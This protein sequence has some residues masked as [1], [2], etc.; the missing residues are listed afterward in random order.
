MTLK[1]LHVTLNASPTNMGYNEFYLYGIS[2]GESFSISTF[3]QENISF[4]QKVVNFAQDFIPKA[5][6]ASLVHFHSHYVMSISLLLSLLFK[7]NLAEK[8]IYTVHTS[9]S[10]LSFRNKIFFFINVFF[11]KRV[12]FCSKSSF[13]SFPSYFTSK[14]KC[15]YIRNGINIEFLST[16]RNFADNF[17]DGFCCLGRLV[18]LKGPVEVA[19]AFIDN[20]VNE[21]LTFIGSG[22]LKLELENLAIESN[23]INFTGLIPRADV[24]KRLLSTKYYI[25]NS[26]V[27]GMPIAALE[28]IACGCYPVLSKIEPHCEILA[29]GV[30][31]TFIEKGVFNAIS[32]VISID[33]DEIKERLKINQKIIEEKFSLNSM[34][35][36]YLE[37]YNNILSEK[38]NG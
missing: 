6:A 13:A 32:S 2:N 25:S 15:S 4:F 37:L 36:K 29:E 35:S 12:V 7:I 11:S 38:I 27:E 8:S 17:R 3:E 16:Q 21:S 19:Q 10:N 31:G 30:Y 23:R 34:H 33:E 9:Y 18:S 28:A 5:R 1:V 26:M 24:I 14:N 20:D 22:V